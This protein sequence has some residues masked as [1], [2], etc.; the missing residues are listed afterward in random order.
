MSNK[1][2]KKIYLIDASIY[3]F[4]AY[5]SIPNHM[6]CPQGNSV[7]AIYGFTHFLVQL[8]SQTEP[9]HIVVCFDESLESCFRVKLYPAYKANRDPAPEDLVWQFQRCRQ[10]AKALGLTCFSSKRFEAD[11]LIASI[12]SWCRVRKR[13]VCVVSRDKDLLQVLKPGDEFWNFADNEKLRYQDVITY[14][15]V[16]A[17]QIADFLAIAG[18]VVDNIPGVVGVGEKTAIQLLGEFGSIEQIYEN[19]EQVKSIKSIRG[20]Y[21]V[22]EK[23]R[24]QKDNIQL[25]LGLTQLKTDIPLKLSFTRLQWRGINQLSLTRLFNRLGFG[26]RIRDTVSNLKSA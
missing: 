18:D 26:S 5:F 22:Y 25:F 12:A 24:S 14:K 8:L 2:S 20:S 4:R 3:I 15:G 17:D 23:L 9:K 10:L 11:D 6:T 19:I 16:R 21:S 13:N 1:N 7:N